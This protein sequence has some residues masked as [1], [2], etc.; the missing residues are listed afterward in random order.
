MKHRN[1][2]IEIVLNGGLGNQLFGWAMGY[3]VSAR[4]G[5]ELRLNASDLVERPFELGKL[6]L[7]ASDKGPNYRYPLNPSFLSRITRKV[8][9]HVNL[10]SSVYAEKNFRYDPEVKYLAPGTTVYGYFQSWKYFEE[11]KA[12]ICQKIK[13][14]FPSSSEYLDFKSVIRDK[15]YVAVHI[16]RGDYIGREDFHGLTTPEYFANAMMIIEE[17]IRDSVICFSDSIEIAKHVLPNC[18]QYFGPES[19]NDPVTILRVMSEAS[20]IIGSNSSLSWWAAYLM[21][22]G[23]KKVFP[24]QWF[25]NKDLDTSDLIP[26]GWNIVD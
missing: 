5:F 13:D 18:S 22:D 19:M 20:A 2:F 24:R 17:E 1:N 3:A 11:Y 12:E 7:Y 9:K 26:P 23:K 15:K 21:E 14:S 4:N 8:R 25:A 10:R 6:G 16:R